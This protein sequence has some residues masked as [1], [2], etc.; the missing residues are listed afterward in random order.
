V[1]PKDENVKIANMDVFN[2]SDEYTVWLQC[3]GSLIVVEARDESWLRTTCLSG[4]EG[5]SWI[6]DAE[7][8]RELTPPNSQP[9][10]FA[11]SRV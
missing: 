10:S 6:E 9:F 1:K 4:M 5:L 2:S 8:S 7:T 11:F 3:L